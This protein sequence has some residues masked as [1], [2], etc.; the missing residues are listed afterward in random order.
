MPVARSKD[1]GRV[2]L[3]LERPFQLLFCFFADFSFDCLSF[4]VL[5]VEERR[6]FRRFL[7]V[8]RQQK[9]QRFLRVRDP[10]GRIKA[11]TKTKPD[12]FGHDRRAHGGHFHQFSHAMP[13]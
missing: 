2:T 11:R 12:V 1:D 13:L 4:A 7:F 9:S 5:F 3:Y 8:T 6:Q 10:A